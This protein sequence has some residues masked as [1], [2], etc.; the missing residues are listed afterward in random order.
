MRKRTHLRGI[1]LGFAAHFILAL[2]FAY[3]G[4][5]SLGWAA[6]QA[7]IFA[8]GIVGGVAS[9]FWA[10]ARSWYAPALL[11]LTVLALAAPKLPQSAGLGVQAA[12][13]LVV[14]LGILLGAYV[15]ATVLEPRGAPNAIDR[16]L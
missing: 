1:V 4:A 8:T 16:A 11:A 2:L 6:S 10:P 7:F 15:Y 9:A 3:V 14:P 13:L 5:L 12:W